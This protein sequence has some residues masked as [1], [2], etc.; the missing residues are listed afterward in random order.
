[1]LFYFL[2]D[3]SDQVIADDKPGEYRVDLNA[4]YTGKDGEMYMGSLTWGGVIM[5]PPGK[6]NLVAHGRRGLDSLEFIPNHWFINSD[7]DI[8]EGA[9]SHSLNPYFNGDIYWSRMSDEPYGGDS[10]ILGA[11]VQDISGGAIESTVKARAYDS[12]T[13]TYNNEKLYEWFLKQKK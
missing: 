5:T 3:F 8:P 11:S 12:W 4:T 9:I 1:M 10:L 13:E 2:G 6:A 7:L